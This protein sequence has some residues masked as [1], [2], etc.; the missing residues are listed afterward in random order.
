MAT[1][2]PRAF[3][4]ASGPDAAAHLHSMLSNEV[5]GLRAGDGVYA[6]LLTP[7]ARVIADMEVLNIGD[8]FVI[9]C[10]PEVRDAAAETLLRARFRKK[11]EIEPAGYAL[12]WGDA[13]EPLA[14]MRTPAGVVTLVA[15]APDG[16]GADDWEVARIEAGMPRF[17][18]EFQADSMPA[19]VGLLDRAVSFSKGCYP[20]QEPIARL[21]YRG[22]ANRGLRGLRLDGA[23]PVDAPV[24]AG[25]REVGTLTSVAQS[26]RL[27][28]IGLAVLRREV[29]DG[30]R[31]TASGF[32]ATVTPLPF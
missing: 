30:D 25:E 8:A 5:E 15:H 16:N 24:F 17:G 12:L 23:A 19:E 4:R 29:A 1:V 10:P 27:G 22:H 21:H 9:A 6:L 26:P 14:V 2:L 32:A 31:V 13:A 11:V 3:L 18:H 7:K 28:S 20:G